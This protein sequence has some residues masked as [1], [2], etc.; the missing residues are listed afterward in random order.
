MDIIALMPQRSNN[1]FKIVE[2]NR[3]NMPYTSWCGAKVPH[4]FEGKEP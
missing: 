4:G 3:A 1:F 2:P